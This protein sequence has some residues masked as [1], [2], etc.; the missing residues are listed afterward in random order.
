MIL[1]YHHVC[2]QAEVPMENDREELEG[3]CYNIEPDVFEKHLT[4]FKQFGYRFVSIDD[5][6]NQ[7]VEHRD[8]QRQML[9]TV[10]F[11][12]GWLDNY[13][14][15]L[16]ILERHGVPGTFFVVS[17]QMQNVSNEGRMSDVMLK[18]LLDAG[19]CIGAH[20]RTHPNLALLSPADLD[21][22]IGG[23]KL[24]LERRI[25]CQVDYIAYPGGRFNSAVINKV[26]QYG[27]KAACS[28]IPGGWNG[29]HSRFWLYREV[30]TPE[31]STIR[32]RLRLNPIGRSLQEL[33][34]WY[35]I[36]NM[37]K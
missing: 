22:E 6:L 25:G 35:R 4:A 36:R 5:Y 26:K 16:P 2:P 23:C 30:F 14:Y 27:F 37:L 21:G 11:D 24:D 13:T 34:S 1:I 18:S 29:P 32:D 10:T 28:V 17:G 15:A 8:G 31:L 19:M 33:R 9:V 20:T 7:N 3:W 12:D